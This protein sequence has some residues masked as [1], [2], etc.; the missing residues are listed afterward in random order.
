[1][2]KYSICNEKNI[3]RPRGQK[4]DIRCEMTQFGS[5]V[6]IAFYENWRAHKIIKGRE[7]NLKK[8]FETIY[9][10][11]E[12]LYYLTELSILLYVVCNYSAVWL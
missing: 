12:I 4:L 9:K 10:I 11:M 7:N 2:K 1:M 5:A 3:S 6:S 8:I